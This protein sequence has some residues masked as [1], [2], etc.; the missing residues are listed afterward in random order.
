MNNTFEIWYQ[1]MIKYILIII[2]DKTWFVLTSEYMVI[3]FLFYILLL[4]NLGV[5][6]SQISWITFS[7]T[8]Y[9]LLSLNQNRVLFLNK[10]FQ[11]CQLSC[12]WLTGDGKSQVW[13][14]DAAAAAAEGSDS[15]SLCP[16]VRQKRWSPEASAQLKSVMSVHRYTRCA[17]DG[18]PR[19]KWVSHAGQWD[20]CRMNPGGKW[21]LTFLSSEQE[22]TSS[23][24]LHMI[25]MMKKMGR[26]MMGLGRGAVVTLAST[27]QS[28]T[29]PGVPPT[30][31]AS[32]RCATALSNGKVEDSVGLLARFKLW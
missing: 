13:A 19:G 29:R 27:T 21:W 25:T 3:V 9:M 18:Q 14:D 5:R 28:W 24:T 12:V 15:G 23:V 26:K 1:Y 16:A 22:R 7:L 10:M 8:T 31:P 4:I 17:L 30:P 2:Y 20:V 6:K 11:A 32:S